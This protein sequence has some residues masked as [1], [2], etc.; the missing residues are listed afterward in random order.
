LVQFLLRDGVLFGPFAAVD[1]FSRSGREA[2][3]VGIDQR[4]INH[5][6]SAPEQFG[7]A[8]SQ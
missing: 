7:A 1:N 6:V 8:Q 3:Q 5:H 2:E 4:V